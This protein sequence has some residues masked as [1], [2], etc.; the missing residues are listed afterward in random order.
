MS[1][2]ADVNVDEIAMEFDNI[3][4]EFEDI[5]MPNSTD[6]V[7]KAEQDTNI[8][9]NDAD[10]R[11]DA[12]DAMKSAYIEEGDENDDMDADDNEN[13][14]IA[15][16]YMAKKIDELTEMAPELA[17]RSMQLIEDFVSGFKTVA[18]DDGKVTVF[19]APIM[20]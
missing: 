11:I 2:S 14:E 3:S 10:V 13:D 7:K 9:R 18:H 8:N 12:S 20:K 17:A 6:E 19:K 15:E 5:V 4:K 16:V 1:S